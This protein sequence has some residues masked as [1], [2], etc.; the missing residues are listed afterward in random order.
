MSGNDQPQ[1]A[2][3]DQQPVPNTQA[4]ASPALALFNGKLYLAYQGY[5]NHS[6]ELWYTT[7]DVRS[8]APSWSTT[9][10]HIP[11][12]GMSESPSLAVFN[13]K[14]YCAH[15]GGAHNSEL[16]YATTSDGVN[17]RDTQ[18]PNIGMSESPS[19][20]VFNG[21]LYCAHQGGAHNSE[22]WYATTSDGV[23]WTDTHILHIG[24]SG[25]PSLAVF[26]GDLYCAHQGGDNNGELWYTTTF[27]GVHWA[28]DTKIPSIGLSGSP[29]S[30]VFNGNLYLMHQGGGNSGQLWYTRSSDGVIWAD[31]SCVGVE[32]GDYLT[33]SGS[34]AVATVVDDPH[35][36]AIFMAAT[37][38]DHTINCIYESWLP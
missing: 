29:A 3:R 37:G 4:S 9:S 33:V 28:P 30:A 18:I 31:D 25:S 8:G 23:N 32:S 35:G 2:R 1:P 20:A 24:M 14:L 19:L 11:Y 17:W 6:S 22:L 15:Q 16:W 12:I 5:G 13:G 26:N 36:P 21:K 34:P 27:N 7:C 38:P 10:I